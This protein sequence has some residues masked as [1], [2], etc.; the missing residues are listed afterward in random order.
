LFGDR[1]IDHEN[2]RWRNEDADAA[3]GGERA[4]GEARMISGGA[5]FRQRDPRHCRRRRHRGAA[6]RAEA[7]RCGDG[8]DGE[9]AA[10]AGQRHARRLE[11]VG[12]QAGDRGDLAHQDEQRQD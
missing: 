9:A 5:H 2:D 6:H 8:A 1:G 7:G 4:G 11:Q 12:R 3:A 10:H